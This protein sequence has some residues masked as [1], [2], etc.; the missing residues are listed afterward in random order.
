MLGNVQYGGVEGESTVNRAA[1][2]RHG[3]VPSEIHRRVGPLG[4][5]HGHAVCLECRESG[6]GGEGCGRKHGDGC[7]GV[8]QLVGRGAEVVGDYLA[9]SIDKRQLLP[10]QYKYEHEVTIL[11][12][13]FAAS[14]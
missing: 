12:H 11:G 13:S 1:H 7:L 8:G 10:R 2:L 3:A 9:I 14:N 5:V 6:H 4:V